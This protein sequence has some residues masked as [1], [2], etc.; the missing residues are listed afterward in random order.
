[1]EIRY[2]TD[3]AGP[4]GRYKM[5]AYWPSECPCACCRRMAEEWGGPVN[6]AC[7]GFARPENVVVAIATLRAEEDGDISMES[8]PITHCPWCGDPIR[9]VHETGEA[10][11]HCGCGC[12][13]PI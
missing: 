12:D 6:L 1:M 13:W 5:R 3:V 10:G 7:Q 4:E 11:G 9:L 2:R 8:V